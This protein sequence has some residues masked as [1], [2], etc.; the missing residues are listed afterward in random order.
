MR[1]TLK[2]P[3]DNPDGTALTVVELRRPKGRDMRALRSAQTDLDKSLVLIANLASL[4]PAQV[5]E[6]DGEDI[7]ALSGIVA[8]FFGEPR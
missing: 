6:M 3:V 4:T 7:T 5:D 8:D 2:F 1:Y